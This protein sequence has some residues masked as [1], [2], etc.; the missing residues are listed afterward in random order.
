MKKCM[1]FSVFLISFIL[2]FQ[3]SLCV[4]KIT[5]KAEGNG[6]SAIV[7]G[8]ITNI[9]TMYL[10]G[11]KKTKNMKLTLSEGEN[12]IEIEYKEPLTDC[13]SLLSKS[14]CYS[15][16][17]TQ[18]D[19][20]QCTNFDSMFYG[21]SNL[22]T[23]KFENFDTSNAQSM[24]QMFSSCGIQFLDL[25]CFD[26]SNVN[27][28]EGMFLQAKCLS[29]DL[30]SF[31][32][33][34]VT[35]MKQMFS[36]CS[37]LISLDISNF[38]VLK[39]EDTT[40]MFFSMG[41]KVRF[42]NNS[43]SYHILKKAA[44]E[45]GISSK[46]D[47]A[48]SC[49]TNEV[50]KFLVADSACYESCQ[51]TTN[52]KFEY[53]NQCYSSCPGGTEEYPADS[54]FCV[55]V[56][57]CTS[58]YYSYDKTECIKSVPEGYYCNDEVKKTIDKCQDK[59]K[60][61]ELS[62]VQYGLCISCNVDGLYYEAENYI[63]NSNYVECFSECPDGYFF[64][65][66][67][68]KQC[69][70]KCKKC[71]G[72][73]N[74]NDNKCT[75]CYDNMI[76]EL[77]ANCYDKCPEGEFYYFDDSNNYHCSSGCPTDYKLIPSKGKC[78]K[79]CK[80]EPPY[81]FQ[82]ENTCLESCP[83]SYHAPHD[84]N[85]CEIALHCDNYYNYEYTACLDDIP[86]GFYC[87]DTNARTI[88]KC[89]I[90][91]RTCNLDSIYQGLCTECN[92]AEKYYIKENDDLNING[93]A[94][95]YKDIPEAYFIDLNNLIIKKCYKTCKNCDGPGIIQNQLCN[96][97]YDTF[98]LNETNC[99]EICPYYYYFD[100]NFEYHC[101]ID[102]KCPLERSKL[103]VDKN[104]CVETCVDQYRFEIYDKCYT[105]CPP[106]S[107]YNYDQTN[108]IDSIPD[109]FYLNSSQT[110]D[111]CPLKCHTCNTESFSE[112]LCITCEN[113]LNFYKKEDLIE[114][115][116]YIDCFTG[117]QD[118]YFLDLD[119]SEYKKCHK[120][121]K[122]CTELGDVRN[123]KCTECFDNA[124]L[125]KTN[126]FEICK[127]FYYFDDA[128]EYF[129][130]QD[131]HCP[132]SRPKL[133]FYT[134][135]CVEECIGEYK[136]EFDNKCYRDCPPDT[137]YDF[138]QTGCIDLIP[139]G[140]YMNDTKKRTIN[141][142]DIKCEHECILDI[143]KNNVICK[144][145]N[146]DQNY[147]K[148]EDGEIINEYYDCF[149]GK[150]E[151]HYL[152][153]NDK[154]YKRCFDKCK[155][156]SETGDILEHK[157]TECFPEFTLNTTNCYEIC[158]YFF[159]FDD[160][161]I[162]HC[163]NNDVCPMEFPNK[164]IEKKACIKDCSSDDI[165]ILNYHNTCYQNCPDR[166][167]LSKD[168]P[169]T[170]EDILIC[171]K[172]YNFEQTECLEEIPSGFYLNDTLK[173]TIDKCDIKC[174][175][176]DTESTKLNLCI[177]CNSLMNFHSKE[178]DDM[179]KLNYINCY[180]NNFE[181]YYLDIKDKQ[182]NKC[183]FK[184][185]NCNNKGIITD[186]KCTECFPEFTLNDTNCY[187]ICKF[188]Y[189]FDKDNIYK[190]TEGETCPNGYSIIP[191]KNKCITD[192]KN[193]DIYK[194]E[195]RGVCLNASYI[196][197]CDNTS[198]Y[199]ER[200]TGLCTESCEANEFLNGFC[201]L[202][203]NDPINQDLVVKNLI[204]S[205][206][207][208]KIKFND[209]SPYY[210]IMEESITYHLTKIENGNLLNF[211][212]NNVSGIN[213]GDCENKLKKEYNIEP[214]LPLVILKIDN[215]INYSL[216]PVVIYEVFHPV[217]MKKLNLSV[218][219]KN[220]IIIK[221]PS[222]LIDESMIY[223]YDSNDEYYIDGCSASKVDFKF[224][225]ILSDRQNYF[226][227]NN[228]S[229]CEKD[230]VLKE[231]DTET[232]KSVCSCDL[233]ENLIFPSMLNKSYLFINE[234]SNSKSSN[235]VKCASTLFSKNGIKKNIAFYI[236][237]LLTIFLII[238]CVQF[239]R[240]GYGHLRSSINN[241]LASKEKRTEEESPKL[242]NQEDVSER[243][244]S[245]TIDKILRLRTLRNFRIDF[246]G[247]ISKDD[248]NFQDNYSNNQRSINKL[249][250]YNFRGNENNT[251][252]YHLDTDK[253][254]N[255]SDIELNS[256]TY[257]QAIG[258]DMRPFKHI[259]LSFIKYNHPILS[260]CNKTKDYNSKY[261]KASLVLIS[262][263]LYYFVNCLFIT[264]NMIHNMYEK[265]DNNLGM[266][267]PYIFI[268]FII[269]YILERIIRYGSLSY[270]N[271]YSVDKE[272]LYNNAKIRASQVRKIL[273]WKYICFYIL[274][275]FSI[276]FF[277]Y[278]ISA[279]GAVYQNTQFI[280]IKN[281][282]ISYIFSLVFPFI[283]II[284]PAVLRRYSLKDATR[285][286]MFDLSRYLQGI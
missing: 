75:E 226:L 140:Y 58:S 141:K 277:G 128:G 2:M 257:K 259:Y 244:N 135:E 273:F 152:D 130:T 17:L 32:T 228:L 168:I 57:D 283:I 146:N 79:E 253:D 39:V 230:C 7:V 203:N 80:S 231:Y 53:N 40:Q 164:I 110:I 263:S 129:C 278:Y 206:E 35:T 199:I 281:T 161:K 112:N 126:C 274:G 67:I 62:S 66:D 29:I 48:D 38:D 93:F 74:E 233:R 182:Y 261:I 114:I 179:N 266:F 44:D 13:S 41:G 46:A 108:C 171:P 218:C 178:N 181:G 139:A 286:W 42:C 84:D 100:N 23:L 268:S 148:K 264:Q 33:S 190:C 98:T 97:C 43:P 162:Y 223:L 192:C 250:V 147:F 64:E 258:V 201:A 28:M 22:K 202:R 149:S 156:C 120:T 16:D 280:L 20:S 76:L 54:F 254:I 193:D 125:N 11:V 81:I 235:V 106:N 215:Y 122:S 159:Y 234:F 195:Y 221:L 242:E 232:K 49:F 1:F 275:F 238:C 194:Y 68:Y 117:S 272:N 127:F 151:K 265:S 158:P 107:Y 113:S 154:E 36:T 172:Y 103:I 209:S 59:C 177:T 229:L 124:T 247:V 21:C 94:Q 86:E 101:T 240:I 69:Y 186:H 227:E 239:I 166:T 18:F 169:N 102:N 12:T 90:K 222:E 219:N 217:T 116:G 145:C 77:G 224:D 24:K 251:N 241:I 10:N 155:F 95:C 243:I 71:N 220:N 184:C 211:N 26:T 198:L 170:C 213:L 144:A 267:F 165:F 175:K 205:I 188:N 246:K 174:E 61:C 200:D 214:N 9:K 123:N 279:F 121:C 99:Y 216:V 271:I 270:D 132:N 133:N 109:G 104:E 167:K 56:L 55:D 83:P 8:N 73:G 185:K 115:N 6:R 70:T 131:E 284:I 210:L 197:D 196:P 276:L 82:F 173:K 3:T 256:F 119:N 187:E 252:N 78:I 25:S 14:V 51:D 118:N 191:E 157:C 136:F 15:V 262:F 88:D 47:C 4:N 189:Y 72:L 137:F 19:S 65:N 142:C 34:K 89:P 31:D 52:N 208:G 245:K 111:K 87:N 138:S 134:G 225:L 236:Y 27:N 63:T 37:L 204:E 180:N 105:S 248:I 150:I 143:P 285:Q 207:E 183:F 176:C 60:A 92:N 91:C 45:G 160:N 212:Y 282:I 255:Y 30:S 50:N 163:T 237:L 269:C 260:L 5:L 96:E 153:L 249:D 85:I